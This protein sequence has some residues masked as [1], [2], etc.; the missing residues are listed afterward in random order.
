MTERAGIHPAN[1]LSNQRRRTNR[2]RK[3]MGNTCPASRHVHLMA[4]ALASGKKYYMFDEEPEHCAGAL[5]S[6]LESLWKLRTET[7]WPTEKQHKRMLKSVRNP[8]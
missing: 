4:E 8:T 2:A 6:V 1:R 5:L 3:F 7:G